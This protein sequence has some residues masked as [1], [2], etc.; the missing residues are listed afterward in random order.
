M[1]T[2]TPPAP[3][4]YGKTENLL[5]RD[6]ETHKLIPG[7]YRSRAFE[8][9]GHWL[10]TEKI[11]GTN[12]RVVFNRE[13]GYDVRGRTD[14]A[15]LPPL[16]VEE[17]L[18][19]LSADRLLAA[20][21]EIDPKGKA[22]GMVVY[23]EGYGPGIQKGG[24]AYAKK[25]SLR[26]FD[27]LLLREDGSGDLWGRFEDVE[28]VAN[29]TGLLTVPVISS[30]VNTES[31]ISYVQSGPL[32]IVGAASDPDGYLAGTAGTFPVME[33]VVARTDPYLFTQWGGRVM[34]KLKG[35]DLL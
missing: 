23:G 28:V 33:G 25:K 16:F 4:A 18:P 8:Q 11:D 3:P 30:W 24:G 7:Q 17:A 21:D 15:S 10:L 2:Y 13:T 22:Y 27:V 6:E 29:L 34:F 32:S 19:G 20:I 35:K 12:I 1:S 26:V 5:A 31:I 9:V 14:A